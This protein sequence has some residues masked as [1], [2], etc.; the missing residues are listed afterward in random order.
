MVKINK[1]LSTFIPGISVLLMP[2]A[3]NVE[4]AK[5]ITVPKTVTNRVIKYARPMVVHCKGRHDKQQKRDDSNQGY[6][7]ADTICKELHF[8]RFF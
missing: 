1:K 5:L 4:I 8:N 6:N 2:Y 7:N 3:N